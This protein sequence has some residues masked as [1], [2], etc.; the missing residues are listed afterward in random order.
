MFSFSLHHQD[1]F[2]RAGTFVT[3]HGI[4]ETPI[5]MPVGTQA[6]VKWITADQVLSTG[7]QIMLSNTYHL[8]L[9]PGAEVVEHF[10]W[11]HS[12]MDIPIPILTDS[13]GFQ[14]FSLG[15]TAWGGFKNKEK[16][17]KITE[18]GVEFRS[19]R[20]GSKHFFTP[21]R[22]M[23]IQSSL[24]ADII[25]AFDE[26]A[27][28][29]SSESYARAAMERTHR[30]ALRSYSQWKINEWIR[31][32]AWL[33]PQTL[34]PIIQ[35]VVYNHLREESCH[36]LSKLDTTGIAIWGLSVGESKEDMYR[37]L[38][39]LAPILPREK[40]RYLMWVGTPEDVV[41][42]IAR[43]IDMF[44]CVLPTRLWRHWEVFSSFGNVK[45]TNEKYKLSHEHIP[46]IPWFE[47]NIS[48]RYSLGY[49]RHLMNVGESLGW[50]L[51]SLHNMEYLI[52]LAKEARKSILQGQFQS[53][54]EE[55]WKHYPSIDGIPH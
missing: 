46:M 50:T 10:G 19:Y 15:Q 37:I 8:Y 24:G 34:F 28:G 32:E 27:P 6:T 18:D 20:D 49:L 47:T 2:A 52:T 21:E 14:V 29:C 16:L 36:F 11:L 54:R 1:G 26:C 23:D 25:M 41:E 45:I 22:V 51:L 4:I 30:W 35:W 3:P 39:T 53:F 31:K 7:A 33:Y 17:V 42:W 9:R 12:F 40:P 38:D 5:F 43:G 13:G 44:D 55:F 48:R